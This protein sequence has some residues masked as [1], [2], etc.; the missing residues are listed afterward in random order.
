MVSMSNP[1]SPPPA[2]E[3]WQSVLDTV[4]PAVVALSVTAVRS[5]QDDHAGA[6]G[7]TG[8]VVDAKRGLLLTNR[9]VCTC[10][11]E[12]ASATFVGCPA[13]EEVA[14]SIAYVDP[15][16]DFAILRFDPEMLQQTPRREI[17]LDPLGCRIGEEIRVI[18]ND[19]LEKLQILSGT[20]ARVDR[21]PPDLAG[22]YHDENTFYVLAASGTRGGSSGSPVLNRRGAAVALNAAANTGSMHAFYLPLHRV[23]RAL[24]AVR[25]SED[26]P[27]GTVCTAFT[28]A[29]FPECLRLGVTKEFLQHSILERVPPFGGTFSNASP[30]SGLLQVQRCL[31]GSSAASL[32]K[33]GDVLLELNGDPCADFVLLGAVLDQAVGGRVRLALCRG[34]Q[35]VELDLFVHDAHGLIPHAFIELGFGIFH[36]VGYQTAQSH[37]IPM[38]GIYVA[39]AG[40]ILGVAVQSDAII[41]AINGSPC[42]TLQEFEASLLQIPDGEYFKVTSYDSKERRKCEG[43]AKMQTRW[44]SFRAWNLDLATRRWT[45]RRLTPASMVA[46]SEDMDISSSDAAHE[47]E[48]SQSSAASKRRRMLREPA[49]AL[50]ALSKTICSI[51][52][53]TIGSFNL[54]ILASSDKLEGDIICCRGAGVVIDAEAGLVLTDR[55]TVPQALGDIEVTLGGETCSAS[56]FF[57]HPLHSIVLLRVQGCC[58]SFGV[59][60][61]FESRDLEAGEECEFVGIDSKGRPTTSKV[62]VQDLRMGD[63]PRTWPPRWRERNLEA[64][65]L[66]TTPNSASSGVICDSN[67]RIHAFYAVATLIED[68]KTSFLGYGLPTKT[69]RPL[70]EHLRKPWGRTVDLRVPSLEI[71]LKCIALPKLRRLPARLRLPTAW[72]NRLQSANGTS[73]DQAV[74]LQVTGVTPGGPLGSFACEGDLLVAVSGKVVTSA[75]DVEEQLQAL[76][77]GVEGVV[78]VPLIFF[79]RGR[80][81]A[82]TATVAMLGSDG[83]R[84]VLCWQGLVLQDVPRAVREHGTIPAGVHIVD[85][86]LGSPGEAHN[87]EG[88]FL[89]AVDGNPTHTLEDVVRLQSSCWQQDGDA[90]CCGQ[91]HLRLETA[92]S[93]G[94]CF[95]KTLKP[96][97]HF[98]PTFELAQDEQGTWNY[99]ELEA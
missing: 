83:A 28:Y 72:L 17:E 50:A 35:R 60:A 34:G 46:D 18:G 4:A 3:T 26:V 99:R 87:I 97:L 52:F 33:P 19:S 39:Q 6:H 30:P 37:N 2:F 96:D 54:D 63:F 1:Q 44:S 12:R 85:T 10:G 71:E 45:P 94:R 43:D 62:Q 16:H 93:R 82:V 92:D 47:E 75:G 64:V 67:G 77:A 51:V 89:T 14:V 70:L 76:T 41:V 15:I 31:P 32:L 91:R 29:S 78:Q 66:E 9:H 84:R 95:L 98:W 69:L 90:P 73:G 58:S 13:M 55:A 42:D 25:K 61:T 56:V 74:A 27:R 88:E 80:E 21:N 53:R 24:Q 48:S 23:V 68:E 7:G 65:V 40:F 11:P 20:I 79:R 59:S 8:F 5:F 22:D 38:R 81:L 36:S 57:Q 86:V 49:G